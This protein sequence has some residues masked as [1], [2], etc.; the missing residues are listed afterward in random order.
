MDEPK[1][2]QDKKMDEVISF[3]RLETTIKLFLE[4]HKVSQ[5]ETKELFNKVFNKAREAQETADKAM[6]WKGFG[7]AVGLFFTFLGGVFGMVKF[8]LYILKYAEGA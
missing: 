8:I 2:V 1:T 6:T 5:K 7:W 4:D 3:T